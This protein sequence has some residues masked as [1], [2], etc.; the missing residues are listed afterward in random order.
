MGPR[1][2]RLILLGLLAVPP[3]LRVLAGR[4]APARPCSGEGRGQLPRHWLGCA[5]DPGPPRALA[6]EERLLLGL[7]LDPNT[8]SARALAFVPGLSPRLAE[9]VV[10]ERAAR[11]PFTSVE[12]LRRVMGVGPGRLG[13]ARAALRID[14]DRRAVAPRGAPR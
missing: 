9:A 8:A 1:L 14:P 2:P 12:D 13:Q 10:E 7:P 4:P 5:A 11:G 6:D 3:G